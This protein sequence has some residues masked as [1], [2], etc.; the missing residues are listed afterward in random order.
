MIL[1]AVTILELNQK[2]QLVQNLSE[3]EEQNPEG[4]GLD[5]R[6]GE[7]YKLQGEGFL[8]VTERRTPDIEKIADVDNDKQVTLNPGDYVLTTTIETVSSPGEKIRIPGIKETVYLL[9]MIFP[10]TTLQRSGLMLRATK[11]DPGF[12]GKLTFGLYNAGPSA[13]TI[14]L[15]ARFVNLVFS[16]A[17]GNL[18][19]TYEGQWQ[20]G[21]VAAE[22]METQN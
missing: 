6:L 16:T 20:G 13:V 9:P 19:R 10:R 11:T 8:G 12:S 2:H 4:L 21:R 5:L 1:S 18:S 7:V 3:R 22:E 15:G 14:E 17:T